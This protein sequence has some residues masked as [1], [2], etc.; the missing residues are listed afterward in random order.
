MSNSKQAIILT[1]Y[2]HNLT[3]YYGPVSPKW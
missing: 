3:Y 2:D 1:I